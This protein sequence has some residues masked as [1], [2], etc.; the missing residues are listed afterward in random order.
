MTRPRSQ[1]VSL[2]ATPYYHCVSRCVRRAY[3]C[4]HDRYSGQNFD[5]RKAW[6]VRRFT[7]L[8]QLF[9]IDIAAYAVMSNHYHLVLRIDKSRSSTWSKTE[10]ISRWLRLYKGPVLAHR[11]LQGQVLTRSERRQ[12]DALVKVWRER[13]SSLSWFMGC[14]NEY[15][16]RRA[17]K[18]DGCTGR[19][20]EGRFRSQ[21]LLDK[22]ALLSCMVYVDLNPIRAN[23]SKDLL[24]SDY[25]SIQYRL[26]ERASKSKQRSRVLLPMRSEQNSSD[27][28]N[29]IP[30]SLQDYIELLEWTGTHIRSGKHATPLLP[31]PKIL[32]TLQLST[33]QWRILALDVQ[34]RSIVMFHGLTV[35]DRLEGSPAIQAA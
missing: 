24:S 6:L 33:G 4:G 23:M 25:T 7:F 14:L 13:L 1:L 27:V 15:M 28:E 32:D 29:E 16:A 9:A 34:K 19:F 20:W 30:I 18:E 21:A 22:T 17:N 35:L 5:H 2:A 11:Y 31:S 12:L 26:K 10:I 8:S 3:L